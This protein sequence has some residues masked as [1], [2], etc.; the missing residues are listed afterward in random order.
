[1][2][3]NSDRARDGLRVRMGWHQVME[4]LYKVRLK[5]GK[6]FIIMDFVFSV[7]P[8]SKFWRYIFCQTI[9]LLR[10]R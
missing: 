5:L 3:R 4:V 2:D 9:H 7:E 10:K 6:F 8:L 1:M